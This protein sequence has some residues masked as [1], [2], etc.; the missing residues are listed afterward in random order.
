LFCSQDEISLIDLS[1]GKA[2]P[3][4]F[5]ARGRSP[6]SSGPQTLHVR[7]LKSSAVTRQEQLTTPISERPAVSLPDGKATED[8]TQQH[9][10]AGTIK[11]SAAD[12]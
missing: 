12:A 6:K 3:A 5:K 8:E 11:S 4:V 10:T 9:T 1:A 2:F 7:P